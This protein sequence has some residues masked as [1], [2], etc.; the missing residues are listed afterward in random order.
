MSFDKQAI[1]VKQRVARDRH[2]VGQGAGGAAHR[3]DQLPHRSLPDPRQGSSRPTRVAQ[4]GRAAPAPSARITSSSNDLAT[5]RA[6]IERARSPA[7][8]AAF[9]SGRPRHDAG[10]PSRYWAH[11]AQGQV[12]TVHRIEDAVRRP[13]AQARDRTTRQAGRRILLIQFG[14]TVVLAAVTVSSNQSTLPFFPLTVEYRE[15]TYAAGKIPGGFI[16]R[17]GRPSD[18]EILAARVIDRSIRPLF[19]EGLQE[20][21]PGLRDRRCRPTR[22]T[23]PTSSAWWPPRRRSSLR[24]FR[25][26]GP[27]AAVRVG[28]VDGKWIL[29]PTFQQLEFS[30]RRPDG[31]RQRRL[32]RDGRGRRARDLRGRGARGAQ[33]GAEGHQGADR[34]SRTSWSARRRQPRWRGPRPSSTPRP[35]PSGRGRWPRRTWP[36]RSTTRTRRG[37][38]GRRPRPSSDKVIARP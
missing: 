9:A 15:K 8:I 2:R 6:L 22:R 28:R 13:A 32:D 11:S 3:A 27:S 34:G 12:V 10:A 25:G 1:M 17:E 24:R 23:T 5:Y 29:N 38:C 14:E 21:G 33:G 4:D 35:W 18:K 19:P 31:Q 37:A 20:R 26:T 16:K 30:E 7:L 36:R